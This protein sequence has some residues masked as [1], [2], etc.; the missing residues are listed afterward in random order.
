MI[1]NGIEYGLMQLIAET[2]DFMDRGLGFSDNELSSIYADWNQGLV[3][4]FLLEITSQIFR[5]IDE[6]THK[7][8]IDLICDQAKQK[9][10]GMWTSQDAMRLGVP[11]PNIDTAVAMRDLSSYKKLRVEESRI[12]KGPVIKPQEDIE[13]I[14]QDL[15]KAL[16][17]SMIMTYSQGFALLTAAS[18]NY[19]YSLA[20]AVVA[21][22]WRGG[23]II[24]SSLLEQI[25]EA[26][27]NKPDLAHLLD[28]EHFVGE[29]VGNQ[30][31]LRNTVCTAARWGLPVPCMMAALSYFDGLRSAWLPANLIQAQRDYFGAHTYERIDEK[32]T[33][34]TKWA[35]SET[36]K[37]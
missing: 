19:E 13:A 1:H 18:K 24:R 30:Q 7:P 33:F 31:S 29:V 15:Y 2:Y 6:K 28:D 9:G 22:I 12:L 37:K 3:G 17:V 27:E 32:G 11:V 4:S 36:T 8:L 25:K 21:R 16:Y 20:P 23:C 35:K 26:Y 34:H 14:V 10:T 5:R